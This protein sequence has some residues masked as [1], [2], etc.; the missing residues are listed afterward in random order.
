SKRRAAFDDQAR[1]LDRVHVV[2]R[3]V[4]QQHLMAGSGEMRADRPPNRPSADHRELHRGPP[5][6]TATRNA[7]AASLLKY[8]AAA[9][10]ACGCPSATATATTAR[11]AT[12]P[13]ARDTAAG[14]AA[15]PRG[16]PRTRPCPGA[17]GTPPA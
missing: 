6:A 16:P 14:R 10:F 13:R 17:A 5:S 15:D 12:A 8:A 2:G 4:D 11:S 3:G 7:R 1:A 9:P